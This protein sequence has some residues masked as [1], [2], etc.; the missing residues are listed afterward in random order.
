[1]SKATAFSMSRI[2]L[3]PWRETHVWFKLELWV[4]AKDYYGL[5]GRAMLEVKK[6]LVCTFSPSPSILHSNLTL[7]PTT[8]ILFKT[9]SPTSPDNYCTV[10]N[11][12]RG[13]E[14]RAGRIAQSGT[15]NSLVN[16]SKSEWELLCYAVY[17]LSGSV[18]GTNMSLWEPLFHLSPLCLRLLCPLGRYCCRREL[19]LDVCPQK[20]KCSCK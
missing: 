17:S 18:E 10:P 8:P 5:S 1:M 16:H 4:S 7:G 12:S 3:I 15:F 14:A 19:L 6:S 2:K 11:Y 20:A 13:I 9:V